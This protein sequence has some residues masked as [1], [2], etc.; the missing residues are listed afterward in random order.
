MQP[1]PEVLR[2]FGTELAIPV[3]M[4]NQ[5]ISFSKRD[6][7]IIILALLEALESWK[8]GA[9]ATSNDRKKRTEYFSLLNDGLDV[10]KQLDDPVSSHR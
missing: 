5:A 8:A 1:F 10:L 6:R 4:S 9:T 7:E 2:V 3:A